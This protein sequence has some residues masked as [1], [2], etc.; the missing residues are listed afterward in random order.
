MLIAQR[1][2][3]ATDSALHQGHIVYRLVDIIVMNNIPGFPERLKERLHPLRGGG[4]LLRGYGGERLGRAAYNGLAAALEG[5]EVSHQKT[6][7][8]RSQQH[9]HSDDADQTTT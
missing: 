6:A 1:F 7:G 2:H 5:R 3:H 8:E 4:L 9:D